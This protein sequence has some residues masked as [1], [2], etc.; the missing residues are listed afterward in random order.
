MSFPK[1]FLW[2]GD[3]SAAQCE[4]AWNED[5]RAAT[6]TDFMTIGGPGKMREVTIIDKDGK[7]GRIPAMITTALPEGARYATHEGV[8]YP[9]RLGIDHYHHMEEDIDLF[10]QMGFKAL[11][12]T[13]SWARIYP[14]GYRNGINQAGLDFYRRELECCKK[15]GIEPVV[16]LYKYD[17]PVYYIEEMGGWTNRELIDEFVEFARVCFTEYKD[18]VKY[19]ITFNEINVE[20][21]LSSYGFKSVKDHLT[22]LHN[23]L[24][25][26]AEVVKLAHEISSEYKVG[27]MNCGI[28]SY[29]GTCDPEDVLMN[30]QIMQENFYYSSDV[31]AKG[32]YPSYAYRIWKEKGVDFTVSEEDKKTLKEGKV[33]YFAFSYYSSTIQTSHS[34][35]T[36]AGNVF[37][38]GKNPYLKASDWGWQIDPTG[39]RYFLNELYNRYDMPLLIVENGLGAHDRIEEDGS[40]HDPYHAEYM[41]EHIKAMKAA[42]EEDKVDLFGYTMW[43][44]IDLCAAS[45]GQVSKR[46]GQI[47]VDVDDEGNG[48]FK[49]TKKDSFYWYKKVIASNGEDLD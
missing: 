8:Y 37:G 22:A 41:R 23:Q 43:S 45:T 28:V 13:I 9:N 14:K 6:E 15:N 35:E 25:A 27:S 47:Y 3:I 33:D 10:A 12:L 21:M 29:P 44:T 30:Q 38:G 2:G 46:Y 24:L 4:G 48:T 34:S 17:M 42:V 19:W 39:L 32:F 31:Q 11:N 40:I 36:T 26:S 49:R 16:T 20:I 1:N 7:P 5:G 18:L